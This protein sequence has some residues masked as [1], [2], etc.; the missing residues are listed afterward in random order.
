MEVSGTGYGRSEKD[1]TGVERLGRLRLSGVER[2]R[3][4]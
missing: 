3:G 1:W 2:S 4:E